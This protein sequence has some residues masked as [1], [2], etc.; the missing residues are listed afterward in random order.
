MLGVIAVSDSCAVGYLIASYDSQKSLAYIPYLAVRPEWRQRGTGHGLL[1]V[2]ISGLV[3]LGIQHVYGDFVDR[4]VLF[5][6]SFISKA[7]MPGQ[8]ERVKNNTR[9]RF[10]GKLD[11][12]LHSRL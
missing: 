6:L 5:Y 3:N 8:F 10:T 7:L 11:P 12:H 9:W 2:A 1:R 4:N